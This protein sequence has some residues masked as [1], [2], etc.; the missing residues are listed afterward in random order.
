[1]MQPI[2][3]DDVAAALADVAVAQPQNGTIDIAG[4]EKIRMDELAR[5]YLSAKGDPRQVIGDSNARYFGTRLDDQS[6]V[7]RGPSRNGKVRFAEWLERSLAGQ[8]R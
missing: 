8:G 7:P 3:S 1:M 2:A 4:P 5:R 6:L